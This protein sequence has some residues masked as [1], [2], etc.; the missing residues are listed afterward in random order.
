MKLLISR[1]F[2][3]L[4]KLKKDFYLLLQGIQQKKKEETVSGSFPLRRLRG[5]KRDGRNA[6]PLIV[7]ITARSAP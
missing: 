6:R 3:I 7:S 5:I 1:K 4:L 2:L